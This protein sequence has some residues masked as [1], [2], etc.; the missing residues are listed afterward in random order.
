MDNKKSRLLIKNY[1]KCR[2]AKLRTK[3]IACAYFKPSSG[4]HDK[5]DLFIKVAGI[6][7][8]RLDGRQIRSLKKVLNAL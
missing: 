1:Y 2:V 5:S 4:V 6:K 7:A 8:L 3:R